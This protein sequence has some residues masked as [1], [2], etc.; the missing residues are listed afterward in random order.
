MFPRYV[1]SF[2]LI[3]VV[4]YS[5][6]LY[7]VEQTAIQ[8]AID[9]YKV[10]GVISE[11][12]PRKPLSGIAVLKDTRTSETVTLTIGDPLPSN[13]LFS[14]VSTKA[15]QVVVSSGQE[16]FTL[17]H[18]ETSLE[19]PASE[20]QAGFD[21]LSGKWEDKLSV[22][23][24]ASA[25]SKDKRLI[26]E[27]EMATTGRVSGQVMSVTE[28]KMR[29]PLYKVEN[30]LGDVEA[31]R[32]AAVDPFLE[33]DAFSQDWDWMPAS[34]ISLPDITTGEPEAPRILE[35]P[36]SSPWWAQEDDAFAPIKGEP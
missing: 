23:G 26:P 8:A 32:D 2:L 24:N 25:L 3:G 11:E 5:Q 31:G 10:V 1:G 18:N 35:A 15:G 28:D 30:V 34:E 17:Q 21:E 6:S 12:S 14:I 22:L 20:D 4:G 19:P 9:R 27:N 7:G 13:E 33:I 16:E 29:Y 36:S